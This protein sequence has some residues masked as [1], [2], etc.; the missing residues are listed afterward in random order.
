MKLCPNK[1]E[2]LVPV[3][4]L[5]VRTFY[6]SMTSSQTREPGRTLCKGTTCVSPSIKSH[7]GVKSRVQGEP[8]LSRAPTPLL[9]PHLGW[10]AGESRPPL[11]SHPP[12]GARALPP[13]RAALG[14]AEQLRALCAKVWVAAAAPP[15]LPAAASRTAHARAGLASSPASEP[16]RLWRSFIKRKHKP[17][18]E[19]STF[20]L[21]AALPVYE[22]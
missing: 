14:H 9:T 7:C 4:P 18:A 15:G 1:E 5:Q 12:G 6:H 20:K 22:L 16:P 3:G 21:L 2:V 17:E 19:G 10:Q 11:P 13:G 8:G